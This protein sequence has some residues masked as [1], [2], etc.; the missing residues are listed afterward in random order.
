MRLLPFLAI[1]ISAASATAAVAS[2]CKPGSALNFD[3]AALLKIIKSEDCQVKSIDDLLPLLPDTMSKKAVLFYKSKSLQGPHVVDYINPRAILSS[4]PGDV[5]LSQLNAANLPPALMLSFNGH[6]SQAGYN[7]LEV[8]NLNPR[9]DSENVFNYHEISFPN[10]S[11]VKG[12][13]WNEAQL[14]I[15]VS[16]ANPQLCVQCHGKPARP[17]FQ[18]YPLW[19]GSYGPFHLAESSAADQAGL[20]TFVENAV[21]D[22]TSRYRH[23]KPERIWLSGKNNST[24][25]IKFDRGEQNLQMN[26]DITGYNGLRVANIIRQLK[27][28][29][30]Y[31]YSIVGSMYSCGNISEF[32]PQSIFESLKNNVRASQL[33]DAAIAKSSENFIGLMSNEENLTFGGFETLVPGYSVNRLSMIGKGMTPPGVDFRSRVVLQERLQFHKEYWKNDP[34]LFALSV[35]TMKRQGGQRIDPEAALLRLIFEGHGTDIS[36]WWPDLKAGTYRSNQGMG[37]GWVP[38]LINAD[39]DLPRLPI[40]STDPGATAEQRFAIRKKSKE[41]YCKDLA[42]KSRAV[43][44]GKT[45]AVFSDAKPAAAATFPAVFSRTCAKCHVENAVGPKIPFNQP[46]LLGD[47]IR[48]ANFGQRIR[49]RVFEAPESKSMPPTR[50]LTDDEKSDIQNYLN[51]F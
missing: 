37:L 15:Q 9:V 21:S 34:V 12:L 6:P 29:A 26:F 31:K 14:K 40:Y 8:L 19:S 35:D 20:K 39:Q 48:K 36:A 49:Y 11:E 22:P 32:F 5:M 42:T 43:L 27:Y 33:T 7:R 41:D 46:E 1:M 23:L 50:H 2:H 18:A 44:A 17:I 10:D 51:Q 25:T 28:Y 13:S 4:V 38:F 45:L 3:L 47:W 30:D 16:E 24:D